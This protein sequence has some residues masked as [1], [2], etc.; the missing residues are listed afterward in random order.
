MHHLIWKIDDLPVR[1]QRV[2]QTFNGDLAK[3]I[4]QLCYYEG[5]YYKVN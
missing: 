1:I 4:K 2:Y 3:V 5:N